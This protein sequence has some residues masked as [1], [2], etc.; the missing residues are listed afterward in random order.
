[1]E[2]FKNLLF[3]GILSITNI[4]S[5]LTDNSWFLLTGSDNY[6]SEMLSDKG[7]LEA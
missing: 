1:V 5:N 3:L 7:D 2:S 6:I 4:L